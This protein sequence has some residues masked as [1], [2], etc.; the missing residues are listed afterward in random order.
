[1]EMISWPMNSL[2]ILPILFREEVT[3][4][5]RMELLDEASSSRKYQMQFSLRA[6]KRDP[7]CECWIAPLCCARL[8]VV[9]KETW[10][11]EPVS[12][13][14]FLKSR[15]CLFCF[16]RRANLARTCKRGFWSSMKVHFWLTCRILSIWFYQRA[17][18][19]QNI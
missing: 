1:M 11:L 16:E 18:D 10:L 19:L 2:R 6:E 13:L 8:H 3:T 7:K 4:H 14:L 15:Y 5:L 12:L 9:T 17:F